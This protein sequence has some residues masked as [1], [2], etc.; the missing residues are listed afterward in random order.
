MICWGD[1]QI[2][3]RKSTNEFRLFVPGIEE[4][5]EEEC[6]EDETQEEEG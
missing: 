2:S 4:K 6:C 3:S 1:F 5:V